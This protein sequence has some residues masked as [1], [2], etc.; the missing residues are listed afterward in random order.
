MK[1]KCFLCILCSLCSLLTQMKMAAVTVTG[2]RTYRPVHPWTL[3]YTQPAE[4]HGSSNAWMDYYLPL[5]NGHLGAMVA[6]GVEHEVVQLSEK[7]LWSGSDTEFG[8]YQ[9]LGYLHLDD[10]SVTAATDYHLSLDLTRAVVETEWLRQDGVRLRRQCLSSWPARCVVVHVDA[11]MAG[12]LEQRICLE[13]THGERVTYAS[14]G[15]AT[16]QTTL[17]T[18]RAVTMLAV[19]ADDGAVIR[20]TAEGFSVSGATWLTVVVTCQTNYDPAAPAFAGNTTVLPARA[21]SIALSALSRGW[22]RLC[23]EHCTDHG[24]L[25]NRVKLSLTGAANSRPT[26]QLVMQASSLPMAER[27]ALEQLFFAYGRYLQI[28]SSR[29]GAVP[30]NLQ[31]IWCNQND[32]PW[33]GSI[34]GNINVEMNYWAAEAANLSETAEPLLNFIYTGAMVQPY[35]RRFAQTM[36]GIS[37]GWLC[38]WPN[39]PLGFTEP[40]YPEH[41]YCATPAW[42]CWHLWQHYAYT[43][44]RVF[45]QRRALPVMLGAVDFWMQ[46]LKW[47]PTDETWVC[48]GEWSPEQGPLDDGTAHTQQCVWNLFDCTLKAVDIVGAGAA[49]LTPARL[50]DIRRKFGLL[51]R[52]LHTETYTGAYGAEVEGVRQGD[53]LLREWKHL[54]YTSATERQHRHLSHLMA[55][56]PFDMMGNNPTLR[57]AA[58]NSML[59]RGERNTGWAMAWKMCLWTRLGEGDRAHAVLSGALQHARTYNVS[60]DPKNAGIYCNLLSAHPPFQADGNLGTTAAICEMLLQSHGGRL[61]LL[62]ALP[63][64]WQTGGEV[65]GLRAEG[66]FLV[67]MSWEA[68]GKWTAEI[69]SLAGNDCHIQKMP[70]QDEQETLGAG[71]TFETEVGQTYTVTSDGN[72]EP[73]GKEGSGIRDMAMK[74]PEGTSPAAGQRGSSRFDLS[75]RR[76]TGQPRGLWLQGGKKWVKKR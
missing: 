61:Q 34:H 16:M 20:A 41:C 25:F 15:T 24:T 29:D 6:G 57:R 45:L 13:G 28:A 44:D 76:V 71:L 70:G 47:D 2:S 49:G 74:S 42:L 65:Q 51:D 22:E 56:Y 63:T 19:Q 11:D 54:P 66:G 35:W 33:H 59:L 3:W 27:R 9:N 67:N 21:R 58:R 31:G 38:S 69:T 23:E 18:V 8:N 68:D 1:K 5:G 43:L 72:V 30:S 10:P 39:N 12:K 52:G 60:T 36:T 37:D 14:D 50:T 75:G 7:T 4:S 73:S 48:P 46:R 53:L 40:W 55:L 26:D 17:Q 32:P 64:A 62:P